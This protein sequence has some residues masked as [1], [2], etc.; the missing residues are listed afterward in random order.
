MKT[1]NGYMVII[2]ML[3]KETHEVLTEYKMV[4]STKEEAEEDL[5][6]YM[7]QW[8]SSWGKGHGEPRIIEKEFFA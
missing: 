3:N 4:Y 6:L 1:V 5:A 2:P 7:R 8:G